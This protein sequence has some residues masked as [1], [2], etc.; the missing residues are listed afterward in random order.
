V[1]IPADQKRSE[2]LT[3]K[4]IKRHS[5]V[6]Y[7]RAASTLMDYDKKFLVEGAMTPDFDGSS[8]RGFTAQHARRLAPWASTGAPLL[9]LVP[10]PGWS[11]ARKSD[12]FGTVIDKEGGPYYGR[13]A[14]GEG[15][16]PT[17]STRRRVGR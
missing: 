15:L 6:L 7:S 11:S 13:H 9:Q 16:A 17:S 4:T 1:S 8:I 12:V 5:D 10:G 14:R 2:F 3:T